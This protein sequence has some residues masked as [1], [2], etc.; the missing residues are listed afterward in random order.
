MRR[1]FADRH[2]TM[3]STVTISLR[4]PKQRP[5]GQGGKTP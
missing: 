3:A 4:R 1:H 2:R 5:C